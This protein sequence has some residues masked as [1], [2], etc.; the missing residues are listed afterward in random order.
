MKTV[1]GLEEHNS[2]GAEV[3]EPNYPSGSFDQIMIK[4]GNDETMSIADAIASNQEQNKL[5]AA[6]AVAGAVA[7]GY[8]P[9]DDDMNRLLGAVD[10][11]DI[12]N[13]FAQFELTVDQILPGAE[14][15]TPAESQQVNMQE[16]IRRDKEKQLREFPFAGTGIRVYE[17]INK[18]VPLGDEV[19]DDTGEPVME[20]IPAY[21]I[22]T[23]HYYMGWVLE[24]MKL[25][26]QDAN[27]HKIRMGEK[28]AIPNFT[29]MNNPD[30][31]QISNVFQR[32]QSAKQHGEMGQR[33]QDAIIRLKEKCIPPFRARTPD[34]DV[35]SAVGGAPSNAQGH[36]INFETSPCKNKVV[37]ENIHELITSFKSTAEEL[38]TLI[39]ERAGLTD[40]DIEAMEQPAI[41]GEAFRGHVFEV[42]VELRLKKG[43]QI[44]GIELTGNARDRIV[45][46]RAFIPDTNFDPSNPTDYDITKSRLYDPDLSADP[47]APGTAVADRSQIERD[48]IMLK[49]LETQPK[50]ERG[51]D[52][53]R[54]KRKRLI[55]ELTE[56]V[57]HY[58]AMIN[59][60][61]GEDP[62]NLLNQGALEASALKAQELG[63]VGD[64]WQDIVRGKFFFFLRCEWRKEPSDTSTSFLGGAVAVATGLN[65]T[66]GLSPI[67]MVAGAGV[68]ALYKEY[69]KTGQIVGRYKI[70]DPD[71]ARMYVNWELIQRKWYNLHVKSLTTQIEQI[72]YSRIAELETEG[73]Q[74]E[75]IYDEPIDLDWLTGWN[76]SWNALIGKS[77]GSYDNQIKTYDEIKGKWQDTTGIGDVTVSASQRIDEYDKDMEDIEAALLEVG[78]KLRTK[79][80]FIEIHKESIER[81]TGG[82]FDRTVDFEGTTRRGDNFYKFDKLINVMADLNASQKAKADEGDLLTDP[83]TAASQ[84]P[85][86]DEDPAIQI[87]VQGQ[88]SLLSYDFDDDEV[89]VTGN[90]EE[91]Q[92]T[93]DD[94]IAE[95]RRKAG[96]T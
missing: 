27:K 25:G 44:G 28:P 20:A 32:Q 95:T 94:W 33:I 41:D 82:R 61:A 1:F 14:E 78:G 35:V 79:L 4:T 36:P 30:A 55:K 24:A 39:K 22:K 12:G 56:K 11:Q 83:E 48:R 2:Q 37:I 13:A 8:V 42:T 87:P 18:Y 92:A 3:G 45:T 84:Q 89:A 72:I 5:D 59:K 60:S 43:T 9:A 88:S 96:I 69:W 70:M 76:F 47:S 75:E 29:Y 7:A 80:N 63:Y 16:H 93:I 54:R 38:I 62:A 15:A 65:A 67:G 17:K 46:V 66:T 58:D 21:N 73:R 40:A 19:D 85:R 57:A 86:A 90:G 26:M 64:S 77:G 6:D 81:K 31:D 51:N 53:A 50:R 68:S 52:R 49:R 74:V 10:S 91:E 23:T 34:S 71:E